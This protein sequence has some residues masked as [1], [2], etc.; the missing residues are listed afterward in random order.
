MVLEGPAAPEEQNTKLK[1]YTVLLSDEQISEVRQLANQTGRKQS[2]ML[3]R[4][5]DKGL[6]LYR[7]GDWRG[8]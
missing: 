7:S 1:P 8:E 3:R 6:E 5:V 2:A 4:L